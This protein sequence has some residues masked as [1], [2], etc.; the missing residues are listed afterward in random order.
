MF[1]YSLPSIFVCSKPL[2]ICRDLRR[3]VLPFGILILLDCF[4]NCFKN[5]TVRDSDETDCKSNLD[6]NRCVIVRYYYLCRPAFL[7]QGNAGA[8]LSHLAQ[9]GA[10]SPPLFALMER[11]NIVHFPKR[12]IIR[13]SFRQYFSLY[14]YIWVSLTFQEFIIQETKAQ[15]KKKSD[16]E[17][18]KLYNLPSYLFVPP[19]PV[20]GRNCICV[21]N[22]CRF[23][24]CKTLLA[25]FLNI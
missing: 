10:E 11:I 20:V 19:Q 16:S 18:K 3:G 12:Q 23:V 6:I 13:K 2:A 7:L 22:H 14:I 25:S 24:A 4:I 15:N 1:E 5:S 8:G 17:E 9:S 21:S